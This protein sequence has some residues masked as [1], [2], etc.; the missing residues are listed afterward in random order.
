MSLILAG[1]DQRIDRG[2]AAA[3]FIRACEG[4]VVAT[5]KQLAGSPRSAA[6]LEHA[7][8]PVVRDLRLA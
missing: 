1:V 2:S 5:D 6:L 7:Q 8:P 3:T 4:P